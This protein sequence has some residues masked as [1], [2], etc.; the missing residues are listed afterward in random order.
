[1]LRFRFKPHQ[2]MQHH[3][4]RYFDEESL[5]LACKYLPVVATLL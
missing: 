5:G 2:T 1:V 3:N 4:G